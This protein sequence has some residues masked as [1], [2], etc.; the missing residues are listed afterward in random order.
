MTFEIERGGASPVWAQIAEQIAVRIQGGGLKPGERLPTEA[1]L[2]RGAG[3]NRHTVRRALAAL[4]DA[5]L[6]RSE[7]GR[8]SFV[9]EHVRD[10]AVGPRT[11]F[12]ESL[13]GPE[14]E[15]SR[16]L[17]SAGKVAADTAAA[18]ALGLRRGAR[19]WAIRTV[20]LVDGRPLSLTTH[21]FPA[22]RFPDIAQRFEATL[23]VS[24]ALAE[25][26]LG[27]YRRAVTRIQAVLP[28][29]A[30]AETLELPRSRPLLRTESVNVDA[31]G[32]PVEYGVALFAADRVQFV[33]GEDPVA[34]G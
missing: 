30:E 22:A 32:A 16:R 20:S 18:A 6:I 34:G 5:G 13:S 12:S 29:A 10:Y 3:V 26:G 33:V 25:C 24:R 14:A 9:R 15:R 31:D 27:D 21:S 2:S 4:D 1:A 7:Q 28:T 8:G 11:R 19:L 17:L 23:S